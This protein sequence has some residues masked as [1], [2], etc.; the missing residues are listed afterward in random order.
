MSA[1]ARPRVTLKLASSLDGRIATAAGESRW[2]TGEPARAEVHRLRAAHDAV[3]VGA[4]TALADDPLLT[5]RSPGWTGDQPLRAVAD[6]RLRLPPATRLAQTAREHPVLVIHASDAEE[7]SARALVALG[8][9]L[10]A[11]TP[12]PSGGL[13][14]GSI[15]GALAAAGAQSVLLEGGGALAAAFLRAGLVDA[16]E[17]FRAPILLGSEGRPAIGGLGL[18][19][20]ADAPA[21]ERVDA[22]PCGNDL[23]ESYARR[24]ASLARRGGG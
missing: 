1:P 12:E 24:E 8:V 20:L 16:I 22:R 13:T 5:V 19:R 10:V 17:W 21:F 7:A 9:G 11:G 18:D 15:L 23:W 14:P 6:A 3:L 4:G 2:I